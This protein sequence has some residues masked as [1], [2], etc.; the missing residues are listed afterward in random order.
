[1]TPAPPEA[2]AR[3]AAAR[4]AL[5]ARE[6]EL[7]RDWRA[8]ER[9]GLG[10][11]GVRR[12]LAKPPEGPP[13]ERLRALRAADR[14]QADFLERWN[15]F[16]RDLHAHFRTQVMAELERATATMDAFYGRAWL[17]SVRRGHRR[18]AR[19]AERVRELEPL[20]GT[21]RDHRRI[22]AF[23]RF[24]AAAVRF[25]ERI[26]RLD[27]T[28]P[29]PGPPSPAD[30][31]A[32]LGRGA[33][34]LA[35]HAGSLW[36]GL[37]AFA[38]AVAVAFSGRDEGPGTP[39]T[40]R[41]DELFR[42]L[43]ALRDL[44]VEVRGRENLP[45]QGTGRTVVLFTPAH[46][47]GETDNVT[48]A[49]LELPDYLVFNAIDQVR[50]LPRFLKERVARTRGLVAV[51]GGRGSAVDRALDAVRAGVSHNV[52]IYPEGSVSEGFRGTRPVR[53]NFG[54]SL[55]RRIREEGFDLHLVPVT[56]LDNARFLDLP[57]RSRRPEER[58]RR[59]DVSPPLDA[60]GIDA[61]LEAGGGA[62]VNR[63][64]RLAWLERLPTGDESLL[65][66][67][68]VAAIEARL[69]R[70]LDGIRYWGSL[71]SAPAADRL[72]FETDEPVVAREVPFRGRRVRVFEVPASARDARG[73]IRVP[74]L[75]EPDSSELLLGIR[76]PA[77][78]FLS[79]G[80]QRFDGDIF[81][82]LQVKE[83]DV[84]YP[85][86]V[87][88][89]LGV[90]VKTVN[91][92]RR[93]LEAFGGRERRTLTCA[94]SACQVIAR[95]ANLEIDD[96]ADMRPFLPSHV[97]PTRTVR[98]LIERGVRDHRGQPVEV[99][100][101]NTDGRSLETVLAEMRR[102]E[103]RIATDH[104]RGGAR[105]VAGSVRRRMRRLG[106]RGRTATTAGPRRERPTAPA[107]PAPGAPGAE[108]GDA[109]AGA[110]DTPRG[111]G[112]DLP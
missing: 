24:Y 109:A 62:M 22:A 42:A 58:L 57:P 84:V 19:L 50:I 64:V 18:V 78:V 15:A 65:G 95:T 20:Y 63:M 88:R 103:L 23:Q 45:W 44:R 47:H 39:F 107:A 71:E 80:L 52:L 81:R 2:D 17:A 27:P 90:P 8:L 104:L 91:A 85:G 83:R 25:S 53:E 34:F 98:K 12:R 86:I 46:R 96:H 54:G 33:A 35:H 99:Q 4:A 36:R 94:N 11:E 82:P 106:V 28:M 72:S 61:L 108:A 97:L 48:F 110:A 6:A 105:S 16:Q 77:H 3:F 1:M 70:E 100:I 13:E 5:T 41:V 59:V 31:L 37:V 51:G 101:Y 29:R 102:A 26:R 7:E 14:A 73:R 74:D 67:D 43:G 69:D 56:Y 40:R 10:Y 30:Q 49:H 76:P 112:S 89:F 55:V 75:T 93:Q 21:A 111:P 92:L 66:L 87:L 32:R 38:R 60:A 9:D 68:R 79:V